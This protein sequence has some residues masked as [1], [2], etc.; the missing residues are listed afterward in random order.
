M[1]TNIKNLPEG[2]TYFTELGYSDTHVWVETKRTKTTVTLTHVYLEKDPDWKPEFQIGGFV[3][4]CSNQHD[5][6]WLFKG[7]S[8]KETVTIRKTKNGWSRKGVRF[9]EDRAVE[10]Y[11][12]N[13]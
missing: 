3:A 6:T 2:H 13:F 11:D 4:H 9:I 1:H 10:F 12:Y 7:F 5:Q 8:D